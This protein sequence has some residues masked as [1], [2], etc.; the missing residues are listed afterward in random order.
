L[1]HALLPQGLLTEIGCH[2]IPFLIE[3][4]KWPQAKDVVYDLLVPIA[5]CLDPGA[6]D[7]ATEND[8]LQRSFA[9]VCRERMATGIPEFLRDVR[10]DT[11]PIACR[12]TASACATSSAPPEAVASGA[13]TRRKHDAAVALAATNACERRGRI[14][15]SPLARNLL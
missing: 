6:C 12:A 13:T 10:D 11:L 1:E 2:A 8:W 3:I 9:E 14:G 15:R 5:I 7:E 4:A